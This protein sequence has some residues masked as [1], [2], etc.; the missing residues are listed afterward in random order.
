MIDISLAL[1]IL[2]M[3]I[4]RTE[5]ESFCI[6]IILYDSLDNHLQIAGCAA[7]ADVTGHAHSTFLHHILVGRAL[8]ICRNTGQYIGCQL[9]VRK[10]RRMAVLNLA[11]KELQLFIHRGI[12]V[13]HCHTVHYLAK[14]QYA[15]VTEIFFH[16]ISGQNTAIVIDSCSGY[17]GSNHEIH[18]CRAVLGLLQQI[19]NAICACNICNLMRIDNKGC[20]TVG[21]CPPDQ[22][23][24]M[25]HGRLQMQVGV[26][27]TGSYIFAF[28][29]NL[30]NSLII[31]N[32]DNHTVFHGNIALFY[33]VRENI[34]DTGVFQDQVSLF[35][36]SRRKRASDVFFQFHT[37]FTSFRPMQKQHR[38]L[39]S[40]GLYITVLSCCNI[41]L[42]AVQADS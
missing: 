1:N 39:P 7:L 6:G 12:A 37:Q 26:N 2:D 4:I 35:Q 17:T 40:P 25:D 11:V 9:F 14:P 16:L 29:I 36:F 38:H 22:Y 34:D 10:I 28:Q 23:L 41:I 24:G 15:A 33:T 32:S 30:F 27:K 18:M 5:T 19:V 3:L 21:E 8:M 13:Y 42:S 20:R 31:T